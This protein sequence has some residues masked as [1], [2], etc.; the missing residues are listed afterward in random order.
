MAM[1]TAC[2]L[3]AG[4]V[5]GLGQI[6]PCF[7]QAVKVTPTSAATGGHFGNAVDVFESVMITGGPY[8]GLDGTNP[9]GPG[10]AQVTV[11]SESGWGDPIA[12]TIDLSAS[13]GV[14]GDLFGMRV[15]IGEIVG[16]APGDG[17]AYVAAPRRSGEG[18]PAYAGAVYVFAG[19]GENQ[20]T[21]TAILTPF[22]GDAMRGFGT[23]LSFDGSQ[24]AVGAPY[25]SG[26]GVQNHGVVYVYTLG[27]DGLPTHTERVQCDAPAASQF[28]GWS[29][30]IDGDRM[31]VGAMVDSAVEYSAGAVYIFDRQPDDSWDQAAIV[32]PADVATGDWFGTD[33]VVSGDLLIASSINYDQAHED[34]VI[35]NTGLVH[36]FK[37]DGAEYQE[38]QQLFPPLMEIN[39]AWGVSI[40]FDGSHL[41]IGGNGW[42]NNGEIGTGAAAVYEYDLSSSF[43]NGRVILGSDVVASDRFGTAV[44]VHGDRV[45]IGSLEELD[46]FGGSAYVFGPACGGDLDYDGLI[47]HDDILDVVQNWGDTGITTHDVVQDFDVDIHDL[48]IVLQ[49]YGTCN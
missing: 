24:L 17:V 22:D 31:A 26:A 4:I 48:L 41:V 25:D 30:S 40:D 23:S 42:Q 37:W 43:V 46:D 13:D 12:E 6:A 38:V 29:V 49:F 10:Y 35:S 44:A 5:A 18:V 36:V 11:F 33:V 14:A 20:I 16:G 9:A 28:M 34:G 19:D 8:Q 45:V 2:G 7:E 47:D 27:L 1:M 21:E 39:I 3:V 15:V 32:A